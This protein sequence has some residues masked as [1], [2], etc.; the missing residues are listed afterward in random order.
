MRVRH[1]QGQDT[2]RESD[3]SGN[4]YAMVVLHFTA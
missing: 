1:I 4:A 2:K 3:K